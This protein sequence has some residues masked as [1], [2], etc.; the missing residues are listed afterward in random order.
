LIV[1]ICIGFNRTRAAK[2][3]YAAQI[4]I[5]QDFF[6]SERSSRRSVDRYAVEREIP[7]QDREKL[8]PNAAA[9]G[10]SATRPKKRRALSGVP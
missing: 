7:H 8:L 6:R 10:A 2:Y 5:P 1:F 3:Y 4:H 9:S